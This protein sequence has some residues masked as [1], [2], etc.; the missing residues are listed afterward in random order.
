[1]ISTLNKFLTYDAVISTYNSEESVERALD[2][3][4][5]QSV[6]P[7]Q[8]FV[9]DDFSTDT[10]YKKLTNYMKYFDNITILKNSEN[11]GQSYSR[12]LGVSLSKS[13]V[14]I[15]F[16]DDDI[17][18]KTR[19][20]D[21][22]KMH[23]QGADVSYVS[24]IKIY[25]NGYSYQAINQDIR[26]HIF[27]VSD[28][29]GKLLVGKDSYRIGKFWVPASTLSVK[30]I[31]FHEIGGFNPSM[32]RL[33]DVEFSIQAALISKKISFS[34]RVGVERFGSSSINK[35]GSIDSNHEKILIIKYQKLLGKNLFRE[36]MYLQNL[37]ELYFT[38]KFGQ[39]LFSIL[40]NPVK[41]YQLRSHLVGAL[42]RVWHD[43]R[44]N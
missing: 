38:K 34:S 7:N 1:M 39:L 6:I 41:F 30:R 4:V 10:T 37:R 19:A 5:T 40:M 18:L 12:N 26:N 8:I 14:I 36:S 32:R 20:A 31:D 3:I 16:D 15:F 13:D 9:I 28:L 43:S 24:S 42:R 2:S 21:H 35:G 27:D 33:E 22:L 17:S 44:K 29:V 25:D 23:S 11:S